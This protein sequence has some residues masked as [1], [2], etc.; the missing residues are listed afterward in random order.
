[1]QGI[2]GSAPGIDVV[3]PLGF[4]EGLT[5]NW[6]VKLFYDPWQQKREKLSIPYRY[7]DRLSR[8]FSPTWFICRGR[9]HGLF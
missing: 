5:A 9:F 1:V 7:R 8:R 3:R 4:A 2:K 6:R